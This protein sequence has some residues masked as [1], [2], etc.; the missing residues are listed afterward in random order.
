[1]YGKCSLAVYYCV[2]LCLRE[3]C[4][5]WIEIPRGGM[6]LAGLSVDRQVGSGVSA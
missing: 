3:D 5:K 6:C 4:F 1:M 2:L